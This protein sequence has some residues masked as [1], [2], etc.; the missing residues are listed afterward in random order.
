M[1]NLLRAEWKKV[2]GNYQL[3]GFLVWIYPVGVL[4]FYGV[5]LIG[6]LFSRIWAEG[7]VATGSG[8]WID[9][10]LGVWGLITSSPFNILGRM[11][12]L[13]F[14]STVFASEYQWGMWK[15]LIPRNRRTSLI[16]SKM[17]VLITLIVLALAATSLVTVAGQWL[18]RRLVGWEYGPAVT[19]SE[20][21]SFLT[22]YLQTAF[23][24]ILVL[25]ILAGIAALAAILTRSVLGGLLVGFGF[26]VL[27]SLSMYILLLAGKI[28]SL[29]GI[30]NLYRFIPAYNVDNSQS[31]FRMGTPV[32]IPV[33][34][35]AAA[36][37]LAFSLMVLL[38]W[39]AVLIA[40]VLAVFQRQDITS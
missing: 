40:L 21:A 23:L 27:D 1:I 30:I 32:L 6:G 17:A 19:G 38:V 11:L 4:G 29:P 34:N 14:M 9:D 36:P 18:G 5:M 37:G 25:I 7:M 8:R 16:L 10:A 28:F 31:W 22:H 2:V 33:E 24:G 3:A 35:F 15:N 39:V 13:A 26:S 20:I 12:P